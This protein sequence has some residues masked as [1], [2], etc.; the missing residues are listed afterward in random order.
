MK[1]NQSRNSI[2]SRSPL[3]SVLWFYLKFF[4]AGVA[5]CLALIILTRVFPDHPLIWVALPIGV[6]I[7]FSFPT[8]VCFE[9]NENGLYTGM[10]TNIDEINAIPS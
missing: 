8:L 7:G 1:S 9:M 5:V 2:T 6:M 4:I 3:H 10:M